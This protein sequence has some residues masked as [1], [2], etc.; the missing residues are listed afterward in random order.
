MWFH[1]KSFLCKVDYK[2]GLERGIIFV[3]KNVK[4][5]L[6]TYVCMQFLKVSKDFITGYLVGGQHIC[7]ILNKTLNHIF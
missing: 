2:M 3:K 7:H 6:C 4:K 1:L 5:H